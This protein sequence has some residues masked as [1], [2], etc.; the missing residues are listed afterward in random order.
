MLFC[1]DFRN[2]DKVTEFDTKPMPNIEEVMN[3]L[4]GYKYFSK[5]ILSYWQ[6]KLTDE[7]KPLTAFEAPWRLFQFKTMS[8]GLANAGTS[9]CRLIRIVLLGHRNV[10]SF[11]VD[12]CFF[13]P[14]TWE[15]HMTSLLQVLYRLRSAKLTAK[16]SKFWRVLC[17]DSEKTA[18]QADHILIVY[19]WYYYTYST[20]CL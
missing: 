12:T 17:Y 2:L 5:I 3:K 7:S 6:V 8:F 10:D 15:N 16:P 9:F 14:P 11:V 19:G 20:T 1:I 18:A 13:F 4:S